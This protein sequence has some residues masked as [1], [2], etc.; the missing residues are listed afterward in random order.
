MLIHC[1][2]KP[3]FFLSKLIVQ[4]CSSLSIPLHYW[5]LQYTSSRCFHFW[6]FGCV[7]SLKLSLLSVRS[8]YIYRICFLVDSP[9]LTY[10]FGSR[11]WF[12]R[13]PRTICHTFWPTCSLVQPK[14]QF[15]FSFKFKCCRFQCST[16]LF[17]FN[18]KQASL[19]GCLISISE[20]NYIIEIINDNII[21]IYQSK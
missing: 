2:V 16:R 18:L 17:T 3:Q 13:N 14:R 19:Q 10:I 5:I 6:S 11:V 4:L 7:G 9:T 20:R 15:I 12:Q 1:R 8:S 21:L